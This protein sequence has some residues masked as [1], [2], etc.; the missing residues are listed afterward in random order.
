MKQA[1]E[2]ENWYNIYVWCEQYS[3][4]VRDG[5]MHAKTKEEAVNRY[6]YL[7]DCFRSSYYE[8]KAV[9]AVRENGKRIMKNLEEVETEEEA[10]RHQE[11]NAKWE[12]SRRYLTTEQIVRFY[13]FKLRI[14]DYPHGN[15]MSVK[16]Q[17]AEI[18]KETAKA[19]FVHF[20]EGCYE[21]GS[22]WVAK[23]I[24]AKEQYYDGEYY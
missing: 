8:V 9:L 18:V 15:P 16:N 14:D 3:R 17:T 4:F 13:A 10:K 24:L 22:F 19:Y 11:A 6:L 20:T 2:N 1:R 5:E 23:S 21:C 12:A 7:N